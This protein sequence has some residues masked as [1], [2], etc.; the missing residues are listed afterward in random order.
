MPRVEQSGSLFQPER[1]GRS[2]ERATLAMTDVNVT[3]QS[4]IELISEEGLN[5]WGRRWRQLDRGEGW[6]ESWKSLKDN[7][8][9][10]GIQLK[11]THNWKKQLYNFYLL[12][13][14]DFTQKFHGPMAL[15]FH[16]I[17][18]YCPPVAGD[19]VRPKP[20]TGDNS[21]PSADLF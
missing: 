10:D 14:L 21:P 8:N 12:N 15:H 18:A 13:S 5:T 9:G 1:P 3:V 4:L 11:Q 16:F 17:H 6:N 7:D 2:S 20:R 19:G